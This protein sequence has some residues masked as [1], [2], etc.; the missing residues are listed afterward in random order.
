VT[1]TRSAL[2]GIIAGAAVLVG[3]TWLRHPNRRARVASIAGALVATAALVVV[4]VFTPL[5]A[6]VLSTVEISASAEGDQGAAPRFEESTQVRLA[7]YQMAYEIVQERPALGYGP[8][9]FVVGVPKY[10]TESEPQEVQQSLETSAHGWLSQV[11]ATSGLAGLACFLGIVVVA[12][13]TTVRAGFRPA[14]WLGIGM[15]AAFLG[16]GVTTVSQVGTEWL[17]WISVGTVGAA[18]ARP[19]P[20][21]RIAEEPRSRRPGAKAQNVFVQSVQSNAGYLLIGVAVLLALLT[22]NSLDAS[23]SALASEQARLKPDVQQAIQLG[24]RST[25]EDPRRAAY[26]DTLGLAYIGAQ[27]PADAVSAFRRA[28]DLAPYD[29]RFSGDLARA[30]LQLFQKGDTSS[31]SRAR[32]VAERV[33]QTDPNNP[34]AQLTRALV[35]QV[36]GDMPEALRSVERALALDPFS[37]N[38]DLFLTATQVYR[39][40]GRPTDAV[41]IGRRAVTAFS[42][43]NTIAIRVEVARALVDLGQTT[44]AVAELDAVLAIRPNDPAALQLRAQIR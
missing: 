2:L 6:R 35:M 37:S 1:Q 16:A 41:A 34:Q 13:V 36:T 24:V 19:W 23:R 31:A 3:L 22:T 29:Y 14:A 17:F 11:A 18:T 5:G 38:L 27:R 21:Q 4:L 40:S 10:R 30:Y 32:D 9:N 15:L 25:S 44:Q 12:V 33:V 42:A 20:W 8:D 28:S 39:A 43:V 26:W 7:F